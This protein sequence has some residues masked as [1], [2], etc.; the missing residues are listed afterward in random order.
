MTADELISRVRDLAFVAATTAWTDQ[1]ILDNANAEADSNIVT[2]ILR[3]SG[4]MLTDYQD[5]P[6]VDGQASY[7]FPAR[8][9]LSTARLVT[10]VDGNGYERARLERIE[11]ADMFKFSKSTGEPVAFALDATSIYPVP[12]PGVTGS[13]RVRYSRDLGTLVSDT[14]ASAR[15]NAVGTITTATA[16][17]INTAAALDTFC[18]NGSKVDV[19]QAKSPHKLLIKDLVV[20]SFTPGASTMAVGALTAAQALTISA[21]DYVTAA[22]TTY[23]AQCSDEWHDMLL[24]S[25]AARVAG[26]RK[27]WNLMKMRSDSAAEIGEKLIRAAQPRTKQNSKMISAWRGGFLNKYR[28]W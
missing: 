20:T 19:V 16:G 1:K 11:L 25:T 6:F 21:G 4:E 27:D 23:T 18:L 15:H 13:L 17:T 8:A 9:M 12:T 10:W 26:L 5:I 3:A 24:Y 2:A 7:D 22:R 14:L 28:W